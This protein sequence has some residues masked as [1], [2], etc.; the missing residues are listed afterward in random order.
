MSQ[1]FGAR[2]PVP[3]STPSVW[4][5]LAR[6]L[7]SQFIQQVA[8]A[9]S[10]V[11]AIA[12]LQLPSVAESQVLRVGVD[13][14][15]PPFAMQRPDGE[16]GG[17]DIELMDLLA[18]AAGYELDYRP[19]PFEFL[20]DAFAKNEIDAVIGAVSMTPGRA[21]QVDFSRP[22]L[23][24]GVA[25][26]AREEFD[27]NN[28]RQLVGRSVGVEAGT[29]AALRAVS[30]PNVRVQTF[31]STEAVL[32]SLAE[33]K[34]DAALADFPVL[35]YEIASAGRSALLAGI[36][37]GEP[38]E[39]EYYGIA[40]APGSAFREAIDRA[41]ETAIADGTYAELHREWFGIDPPPLP[42][43]VSRVRAGAIAS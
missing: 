21:A 30:L 5:A 42:L 26:A 41:L 13:P 10:A 36:G 25:I 37:V 9:L 43:T 35:Q 14:D 2:E 16:L 8:L 7:Y 40:F 23:Q 19:T 22:Y 15:F 34:L 38:L 18:D 20:P 3:A 29:T 33:G 31:V 11:F 39:K 27:R 24:A 17:F 1:G 28:L 4:S 32:R 12:A 6:M